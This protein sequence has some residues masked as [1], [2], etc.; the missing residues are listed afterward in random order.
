MRTHVRNFRIKELTKADLQRFVT[1]TRN[2]LSSVVKSALCING[3]V[4]QPINKYRHRLAY[5]SYSH[6]NL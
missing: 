2:I 3:N 6:H 4:Y 1:N 5:I